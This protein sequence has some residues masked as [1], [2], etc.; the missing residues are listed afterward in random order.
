M[1]YRDPRFSKT[2]TLLMLTVVAINVGIVLGKLDNG[3]GT[4]SRTVVAAVLFAVAVANLPVP[5]NPRCLEA[6]CLELPSAP[7]E[8][9]K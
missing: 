7:R 3:I 5:S 9:S 4:T 8:I 2:A 1:N 6:R